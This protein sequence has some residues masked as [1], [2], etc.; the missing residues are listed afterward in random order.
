MADFY[1][2]GGYRLHQFHIIM[3]SH[4]SDLYYSTEISAM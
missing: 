4:L 3:T 1:L 2:L